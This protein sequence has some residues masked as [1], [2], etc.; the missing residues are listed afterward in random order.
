MIDEHSIPATITQVI[1]YGAKAVPVDRDS[2]P[3]ITRYG[4]WVD[5]KDLKVGDTGR[6]YYVVVCNVGL[7]RFKKDEVI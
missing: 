3:V 2:A 6:L 5:G 7:W 1:S 4:Y